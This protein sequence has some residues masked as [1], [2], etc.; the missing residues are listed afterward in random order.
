MVKNIIKTPCKSNISVDAASLSLQA[1]VMA[2]AHGHAPDLP[3]DFKAQAKEHWY[4]SQLPFN[5]TPLVQELC[6]ALD[7]L[8]LPHQQGIAL[9]EGLV[10][11][12]IALPEQQV[13]CACA[14]T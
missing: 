10:R 3:E 13:T 1:Y 8:Q 5:F 11:I 2:Q 4:R 14:Q 9:S 6:Q 7:G 12:D